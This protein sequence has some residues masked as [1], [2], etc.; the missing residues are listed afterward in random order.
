[1]IWFKDLFDK[2]KLPTFSPLAISPDMENEYLFFETV[3]NEPPYSLKHWLYYFKKKCIKF[4]PHY[5][6]AIKQQIRKGD[7]KNPHKFP[8]YFD[9]EFDF[10]S[11]AFQFGNS[12][13]EIVCNL[14]LAFVKNGELV[15]WT[16]YNILP[17]DEEDAFLIPKDRVVRLHELEHVQNFKKLWDSTLSEICNNNLLVIYDSVVELSILKTLFLNYSIENFN[18]WYTDVL[19]LIEFSGNSEKLA[20]LGREFGFKVKKEEDAKEDAV[21]CANVF[22]ELSI[23]NPNY[24]NHIRHLDMGNYK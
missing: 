14:G 2:E 5:L 18:F 12:P 10:I 13:K 6:K 9:N 1:M 21:T 22:H 17:P 11:M 19:S 15:Y 23:V 4:K 24:L 7:F 3:E 8:D 16:N 20:E